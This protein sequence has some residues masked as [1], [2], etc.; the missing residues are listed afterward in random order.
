MFRDGVAAT[1]HSI[2][3]RCQH[4]DGL[5]VAPVRGHELPTVGV[6]LDDF[7]GIVIRWDTQHLDLYVVLI[8]PEIRHVVMRLRPLGPSHQRD[9]AS[10]HDRG[11]PGTALDRA[12]GIA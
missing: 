11:I 2:R 7:D 5:A 4:R 12:R 8:G 10:R 6:A 3:D 1:I 9:I